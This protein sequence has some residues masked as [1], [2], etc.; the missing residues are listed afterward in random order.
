MIHFD[1]K[2]L[3]DIAHLSALK[4]E[5]SQ[6][7]AFTQQISAIL[8]YVQQLDHVNIIGQQTQGGNVNIFRQDVVIRTDSSTILAQAPEIDESYF[9]VPT[10]LEEK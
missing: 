2:E 9:V 10:I 4:L 6:I 3:M 8:S 5:D 1:K 7:E